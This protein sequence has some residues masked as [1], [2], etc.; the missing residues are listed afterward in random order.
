VA[1]SGHKWGEFFIAYYTN[2]IFCESKVIA[3][4]P[5]ARSQG[6][7][8][9]PIHC[10]ELHVAPYP[11]PPRV[12]ARLVSRRL[13]LEHGK[14]FRSANLVAEQASIAARPAHHQGERKESAG[15]GYGAVRKATNTPKE[16]TWSRISIAV[17]NVAIPF[18]SVNCKG[19]DR[20][21]MLQLCY[22]IVSDS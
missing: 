20:T 2:V 13:A 5:W 19:V 7:H 18:D 4:P 11:V 22:C 8:P 9:H 10:L 12:C 3:N 14:R 15:L 16:L 6:G 1:K 17:D 21:V